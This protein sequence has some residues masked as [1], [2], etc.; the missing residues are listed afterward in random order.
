M[1]KKL[2]VGEIQDITKEFYSQFSGT[3]LL[4]LKPGIHFVCTPERDV[5]LK[6][7]GCKYTV[8][9]LVNDD[10]V[11]IAYSPK[12]KERIEKFKE[13]KKEE[14]LKILNRNDSFKKMKLMIFDREVVTDYGNAKVLE[15][16]DYPLYEEFFRAVTPEADPEGWLS[17][18]FMEKAE[19]GYFT[20]YYS[21]GRLLSVCEAP[22]MPY[23]E[24]R[25]QHTG[26]STLKEERRKGYATCV[27]ALA[28]HNLIER[29]VCPQW[30]CDADNT[31]SV[32]VAK[33]AGYKE[34]GEAYILEEWE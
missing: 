18:Y 9:V 14:L 5:E 6:G 8:Y 23:M 17:E 22:D 15:A 30:E 29:G 10:F 21:D 32:K 26:I 20:G 34:Y 24:E 12:Y 13:M 11:V 28:A 16:A 19:K 3:S 4:N 2:T 1:G 27:A 7:F 33:A 31:G 25:I